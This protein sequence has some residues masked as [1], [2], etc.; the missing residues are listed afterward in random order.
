MG[1]AVYAAVQILILVI[2]YFV[3][4]AGAGS[5][6]KTLLIYGLDDC[7]DSRFPYVSMRNS[8][9]AAGFDFEMVDYASSVGQTGD[10]FIIPSGYDPQN[11]VVMACGQNA[12]DVMNDI[13]SSDASVAGFVLVSPSY[14]GNAATEGMGP[15]YPICEVAIFDLE[16]TSVTV[17]SMGDARLLFERLSGVDTI[18]GTPVSRGFSSIG[19]ISSDTSRYLSLSKIK[20]GRLFAHPSFQTELS[21]WLKLKYNTGDDIKTPYM[22]IAI[23]DGLV[24]FATLSGLAA[25]L[26]FIFFVPVLTF[27]GEGERS[28][29]G[30]VPLALSLALTAATII[31]AFAY[32]AA[33][34]YLSLFSPPLIIAV[35]AAM[36]LPLLLTNK[37][38]YKKRNEKINNT[39]TMLALEA[40]FF[41]ILC[42]HFTDIGESHALTA[43]AFALAFVVFAADCLSVAGLGLADKK[44]RFGG[45]G[46]ISYFGNPLCFA[47][48]L[49]PA[50]AALICGILFSRTEITYAGVCGL[51]TAA[52][53]YA[54]ALPVKRSSDYF[55]LTG[56]LHAFCAGVLILIF[57]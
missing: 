30:L 6:G 32:P 20:I 15:S 39:A 34:K 1:C 5:S 44:S 38:M 17:D 45:L 3:S 22:R 56:L 28:R 2:L 49:F 26:M 33:V 4:F 55:V 13:Y 24:S 54:A 53:P 31:L 29:A 46:A 14:P 36:R 11:V 27:T 41:L 18:Y 7:S 35:M 52:V 12:F 23:W 40:A 21:A 57:F 48:T 50:A 10:T 47:E 16:S 25:L 42:F 51:L 19:Y 37:V 9:S 8:L 43:G